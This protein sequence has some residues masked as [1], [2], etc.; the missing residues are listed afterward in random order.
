MVAPWGFLSEVFWVYDGGK[1]QVD[2]GVS[3]MGVL[4]DLVLCILYATAYLY[5]DLRHLWHVLLLLLECTLR[6]S[7]SPSLYKITIRVP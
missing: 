1:V 5:N 3:V 4:S 6:K 2:S 7:E